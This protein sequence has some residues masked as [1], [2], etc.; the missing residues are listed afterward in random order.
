MYRTCFVD[1]ENELQSR[2]TSSNGSRCA[3]ASVYQ[4]KKKSRAPA[5][6][7]VALDVTDVESRCLIEVNSKI[8]SSSITSSVLK[9]C[10]NVLNAPEFLNA[11]FD[12]ATF[13]RSYVSSM[14]KLMNAPKSASDI[15][16]TPRAH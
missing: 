1:I 8:L 2:M 11:T 6:F 3:S 7:A 10:N 16:F 15:V 9:S 4:P 13:S 14:I 12:E 5:E